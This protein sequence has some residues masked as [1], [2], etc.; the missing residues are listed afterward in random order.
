MHEGADAVLA[1]HIIHT[2]AEITFDISANQEL[3][4][5]VLQLCICFSATWNREKHCIEMVVISTGL[6]YS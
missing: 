2:G 5:A 1:I 3:A 6:H 4:F